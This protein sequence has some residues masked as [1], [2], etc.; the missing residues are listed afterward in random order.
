MQ[1]VINKLIDKFIN[2][3]DVYYH[4]ESLWIIFS[5]TKQWVI[6]LTDRNIL[7]YNY[8]F[9]KQIFS[10]VS[11]DVVENQHYIT[12]WA[13]DIIQSRVRITQR[14]FSD[15]INAVEYTIQNGVKL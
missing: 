4:N 12:K 14:L 13:E 11:L 2:G 15:Y 5:D 7:W 8:G 10:F 9:F 3:S 1:K 6:E